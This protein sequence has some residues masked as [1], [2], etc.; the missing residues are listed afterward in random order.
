MADDPKTP[1]P[2]Q[3]VIEG[4]VRGWDPGRRELQIGDAVLIVA[5]EVPVNGLAPGRRVY[6]A[7]VR[8]PIGYPWVVSILR[9]VGQPP[10]RRSLHSAIRASQ[11]AFKVRRQGSSDSPALNR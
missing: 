5:A 4:E 2:I 7:G 1:S 6:V 9:L 8:D 11:A 10:R 3:F